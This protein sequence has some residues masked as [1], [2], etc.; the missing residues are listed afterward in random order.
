MLLGSGS[1]AGVLADA[2]TPMGTSASGDRLARMQ[3]SPQYV[4]GVFENPQPMWN[5]YSGMLTGFSD[6]SDVA[7]ADPPP[8]SL[9]VEPSVY[10]T[11]ADLRVSW[12]GHSSM[13]FEVDGARFLVDP[14]WGERAGPVDW[15]GPKRWY[16]PP[17]ALDELPDIDA[18]L[19]SHDHYDHLDHPTFEVLKGWDTTFIVPLGV[20]A[21]LEYWG[22]PPERIVE[23]DWWETAQVGEVTVTSTP[24]RHASGR[25]AFD[26]MATLW[27]GFA[28]NGPEHDLY[29]SGDTGWFD[30]LHDIGERLGPF[31]VAL[32]EVGAYNAAW[33]DW[34]IG[35][36]CPAQEPPLR[37]QVIRIRLTDGIV[38]PSR[39]DAST[40]EVFGQRLLPYLPGEAGQ[41]GRAGGDCSVAVSKPSLDFV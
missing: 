20:G 22:V 17:I 7:E 10:E 32:V 13:L 41:G 19:I 24:A 18:V 31:D 5:D 1:V 23:L 25:Q 37:R 11:G 39:L 15:A 14:I 30:A 28:L 40:G 35:L 12:F 33:P 6:G 34:H 9:A 38:A 4:D 2:W 26:Q 8:P 36:P 21:H 27:T 16:A 3:A 29:Y